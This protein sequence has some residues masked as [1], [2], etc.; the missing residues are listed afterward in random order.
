MSKTKGSYV[1]AVPTL[2]RPAARASGGADGPLPGLPAAAAAAAAPVRSQY[3]SKRHAVLLGS[4]AAA[5]AAA[6]GALLARGS[7]GAMPAGLQ[8]AASGCLKLSGSAPD[9]CGSQMR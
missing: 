9:W 3:V 4:G 5:A 7:P 6:A 2:P 8:V 1:R